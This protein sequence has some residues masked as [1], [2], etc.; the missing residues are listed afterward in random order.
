MP[1][2]K[3]NVELLR[4]TPDPEVSAA[5]GARLCYF[6]ADINK[7]KEK[8]TSEESSKLL[9]KLMELGH[10]SP[11][12]HSVFTFGIEGVSRTLTHQ[13]VR[14]RIASYSHQSQR[15]VS[16]KN[17]NYIIP[18]SIRNNSE[19]KVKFEDIMLKLQEAYDELRE[20]APKEDARFILPNAAETKIIVTMNARSLKNFFKHRCCARAQWE[21]R[22]L[23]N[24]MLKLCKGV[25]PILFKDMGATCMSEKIC[26]EGKMH[27]GIWKNIPGAYLKIDNKLVTREEYEKK[28]EQGD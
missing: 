16:A 13:L 2:S 26:G 1:E 21:I 18:P 11:V 17:F 6:G 25:A 23:A 12:E 3:L 20:I 24:Q 9:T 4:Y 19:S 22:I 15:Y 14:H 28:Y 5:M 7:L 10:E 27:C 8:M